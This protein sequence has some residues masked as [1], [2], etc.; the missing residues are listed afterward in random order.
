MNGRDFLFRIYPRILACRLA[1]RLSLMTPRP[2]TLTF[3]V[4]NR[5]QSRC[6]TCNIWTI[7]RERRMPDRE[8]LTLPEIHRIFESLGDIYFFNISGGE[9]FLRRDLPEIV[10][11]AIDHLHPA[12]VHIPTNAIATDRIASHT[13]KILRTMQESA[14]RTILTI[15]PSLDGIG[16]LHD[17]IRGVKGNWQRLLT[18]IN[19]LLEL[20]KRYANLHVE[21]GTVVSNFNKDHL[22]EI[23]EFVHGLGVQSYRN[24]IAE[25]RAEFMNIGDPIT[26]TAEE[27]EQLMKG[28]SEKIRHSLGEK[29]SLAK[30]TESLRLVYYDLAVRIVRE[31]RQV[32]PCYAGISNLHLNYDG[33][34]WP[35]CVLGYSKPLGNLR[36][37]DY[38]VRRILRSDRAREVRKYIKDRNCACPLANQAYSNVLCSPRWL[39]KVMANLFHMRTRRRRP[40]RP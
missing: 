16:D 24:E 8:E 31:Q 17:E 1:Y 12:I 26:P 23:E 2:I 28:F 33:E 30:V 34:V 37:S 15:K 5:C 10:A 21:I 7:H 38:D 29:R 13:E 9:P 3:S 35:C 36:D 14:P 6:K 32:I 25:Q 19:R 27:Y 22:D 4:T 39:M 20:E 18:T 40:A 11:A